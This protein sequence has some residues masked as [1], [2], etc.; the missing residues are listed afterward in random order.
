MGTVITLEY[1][2][3]SLLLPSCFTL[4]VPRIPK[5]NSLSTL[6]LYL[7]LPTV[8]PTLQCI[9]TGILYYS[10]CMQKLGVK[11][12][13]FYSVGTRKPLKTASRKETQ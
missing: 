10:G 1:I 8:A 2:I 7:E 9:K 11:D 5:L 13:G 3:L 6:Y 4:F 12:L